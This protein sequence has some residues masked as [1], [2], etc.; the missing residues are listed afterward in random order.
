M[1]VS[2][3]LLLAPYFLIWLVSSAMMIGSVL[4]GMVPRHLIGTPV[5]LAL[6]W[7]GVT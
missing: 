3:P 7:G 4:L 5:L 6:Y 1:L 2:L